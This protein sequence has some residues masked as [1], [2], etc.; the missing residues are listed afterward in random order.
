VVAALAWTASSTAEHGDEDL[1]ISATHLFP[2]EQ[3][4]TKIGFVLAVGLTRPR[5]VGRFWID[6]RD[7][8]A[9]PRI[10]LN[11]LADPLDRA[12]LIEG[13]R[14][15]R[16]IGQTAPMTEL[17]HS[18]ISP[19]RQATMDDEIQASINETLD[20]YHHPVSTAPMGTDDEQ[21]AV[22][23]LQ[24]RVRGVRC[25]RVIDASIFPDAVSTATNI[26]TVAV[27]EHLAPL[28]V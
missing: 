12:R 22:V 21:D 14:L 18:E 15:A 13:V 9:S 20:T 7:P 6:S 19:G 26:T 2:H 8:K 11:F 16:R 23:D 3:S 17:I 10:D 5:S 24:G 28:I 1:H 27:A 4:P 25:L